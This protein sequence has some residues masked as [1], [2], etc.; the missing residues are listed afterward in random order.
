MAVA[1][2][3]PRW[4][5]LLATLLA[6]CDEFSA[7]PPPPTTPGGSAGISKEAAQAEATARQTGVDELRTEILKGVIQ[8]LETA[9][10]SPGGQNIGI[11]TENLNKYFEG[12]PA[13]D[14][15]L[16]D[17]S[18]AYLTEQLKGKPFP[19][20]QFDA[21]KF[22]V[23]DARH[24]EDCL[25]YRNIALRI[26]GGG[27][28]ME[29]VRR[30]FDWTV[31][32]VAL[33]PAGS[34]VPSQLASQ[35]LS[36]VP[37]RPYD[38]LTRGLATE[39]PASAWSERG[40]CFVSLCRQI[41]VDAG[42]IAFDL[43]DR[44]GEHDAWCCAVLVDG[45]PYLFDVA[46]GMEIKGPDGA[47]VATLEQ[48]ATVPDVL[49]RLDLP[50]QLDYP[51]HADKLQGKVRVLIDSSRQYCAPRMKL[52]QKDLAGSNRMIV[53][54]D[55]VE[56]GDA[57]RAAMG[58][59][60]ESVDLWELPLSVEFRLFNDPAFVASTQFVNGLFTH[61]LPL[62]GA[63]L[64]HLRGDLD[65]AKRK[66]VGFRFREAIKIGDELVAL[67]PEVKQQLDQYSTHFLALCHLEQGNEEESAFLFEQLLALAPS[68][69][70][71]RL[72]TMYGWG[73]NSNLGRI[74][75]K[76]GDAA[77]AERFYS[78]GNPTTEALG[79]LVRARDLIWKDP[80]AKGEDPSAGT[81]KTEGEA[82]GK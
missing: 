30:L 32:Q 80:F 5:W 77:K 23:K 34:L 9:A 43:K 21:P 46:R 4:L 39:Q 40:W 19:I 28:T 69:L 16:S 14:F 36:H 1:V 6:G 74:Y 7:A 71:G 20:E 17:A 51:V 62:L 35:G 57:F 18:R 26:A 2:P 44:P 31:K 60:L 78:K 25:M 72:S 50:G 12:M 45:V 68:P 81:V 53:Y 15:R 54:R 29:K 3:L 59:R 79:N 48:A 27:G 75:D 41:N 55:P 82:T 65:E 42:L 64:L 37:A 52:L 10:D 22:E 73:A 63:R 49:N 61:E 24:I 47:Q 11:A 33:V 13:A 76:A 66:Y 70:A 8:L 67:P 58:D 38:V 56:Q